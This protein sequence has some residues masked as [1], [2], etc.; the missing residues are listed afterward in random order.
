MRES[1]GNGQICLFY[2]RIGC[3]NDVHSYQV[4]LQ[5]KHPIEK[6]LDNVWHIKKI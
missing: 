5:W 3:F 4:L 1:S 6:E 2:Y